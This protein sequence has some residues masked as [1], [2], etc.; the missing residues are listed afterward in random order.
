[1]QYL[2]RVTWHQYVRTIAGADTN[3]QI[4]K[5]TGIGP[6]T[7]SRW[8][9]A[10]PQDAIAFARGYQQPVLEALIAAGYI[11]ATEATADVAIEIQKTDEI[12]DSQFVT[13]LAQRLGVTIHTDM[14]T[15]PD[16]KEPTPNDFDLAA[17]TIQRPEDTWAE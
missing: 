4:S 14:A 2:E 13:M 7:I 3:V 9:T 6:S 17:G 10:K 12:S 16:R 5:K 15:R 1:M 8:G 11:T